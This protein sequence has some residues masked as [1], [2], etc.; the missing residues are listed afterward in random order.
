MISKVII[1]QQAIVEKVVFKAC[2]GEAG[3]KSLS[4]G[5]WLSLLEN[6]VEKVAR[7]C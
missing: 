6:V 2:L 1:L 3:K 5:C 4:L 7:V